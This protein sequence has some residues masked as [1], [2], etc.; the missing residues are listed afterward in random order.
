MINDV[1]TVTE[2]DFSWERKFQRGHLRIR[3][4]LLQRVFIAGK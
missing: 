3:N 2:L 1:I 4:P